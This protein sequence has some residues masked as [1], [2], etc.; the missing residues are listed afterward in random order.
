[1]AAPH[2]AGA[3][4]ILLQAQPTLAPEDVRGLLAVSAANDTYTGRT[5]GTAPGADPRNWW[6]YGKLNVRDALLALSGSTASIL[7]L[8]AQPRAPAGE[9]LGKKGTR[10]PL[11][12][13]GFEA[14]GTEPV[15]VTAIGFDVKGDDPAARLLLIG[16]TNG[17]G[18]IDPS[19]PVIASADLVLA[20][21]EQRVVLAPPSFRVQPL[22]PAPVLAAVELS[23]AAPNGTVFEAA[24][25]PAELHSLGVRSGLAD[26]L[27]SSIAATASG[28][29]VVTLLAEDE[30]LSFSANPVR[31]SAVVFNF[32]EAPRRA[33][34]YTLTGRRVADLCARGLRCDGGAG[35]THVRWDLQNDEGQRVAPAVYL[36]VF[37]MGDRMIR[38]KL[39]IMTPGNGPDGF[40]P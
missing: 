16:D 27:D 8:D 5:Y 39:I 32:V 6:G 35:G 33:S 7:A 14:H 31:E 34:V 18:L 23:G 19:E 13:L 22:V 21:S 40:A 10:L 25:V 15:D 11:L 1:M 24:L 36:V 26:Q 3:I 28:P 17:D 38:E 12:A 30:L 4:A 29:A 20:G 2:V 37:Q 9:T